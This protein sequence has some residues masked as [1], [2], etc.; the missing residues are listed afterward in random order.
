MKFVLS[1]FAKIA[2]FRIRLQESNPAKHNALFSHVIFGKHYAKD[3]NKYV[4]AQCLTSFAKFYFK[5][6]F[7]FLFN[8][9]FRS[10]F[11]LIHFKGLSL[12]PFLPP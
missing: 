10:S 1:F 11:K 5:Q 2:L 8:I 7:F 9:K 3:V 12:V 6:D 4:D